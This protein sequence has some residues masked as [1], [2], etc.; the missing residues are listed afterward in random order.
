M[1][2]DTLN[3]PWTT[4]RRLGA[5]VLIA[6]SAVA[7]MPVPAAAQSDP[8][9]LTGETVREFVDEFMRDRLDAY[10]IPGAAVAVVSGGEQVF[11]EGYGLADIGAATPVEA[12][13]TFFIGSVPKLFTAT[14][15]M[16]QVEAGT[17]D[18]DTDVNEYLETFQIEDA[19]PGQPITLRHLL[20]H[21]SGFDALLWGTGALEPGDVEPLG[22]FLAGR[23]PE[24]VRPPG[25]VTSYDNYAVALAGHLVEIASGRPYDAY[26]QEEI[27]DPL[28]MTASSMSQ[29]A[30]DSVTADLARG[31]TP[32][33]DGGQS[34]ILGQHGHDAPA[35]SGAIS[36]AVDMSRFML[37]HLGGG[38]IDGTRILSE[39]SAELMHTRQFA[40]DERLPGLGLSFSERF[41]G[42]HRLLE[43]GGDS[44]GFHAL[45]SLLPE[46]DTGVFAVVN[47]DG[48]GDLADELRTAFVDHFFPSEAPQPTPDHVNTAEYG[49]DYRIS[50][51]SES[52]VT[53]VL[54]LIATISV[55]DND[56]G[57]IDVNGERY[58][59]VGPDL[60]ASDS[61]EQVAFRRDA[62]G[63]YLFQ[64]TEP[65]ESYKR[66]PWYEGPTLHLVSAAAALLV[67]LTIVWWPV[68]AL[69]RRRRK[70]AA[71]SGPRVP[72]VLA[73]VAAGAAIAGVIGLVSLGMS[74]AV[75]EAVLVGGTAATSALLALFS[76][77]A[78]A[79]LATAG[80]VAAAWHRSWWG[81]ARR[82][83]YTLIAL[84]LTV[85]LAVAGY[86]RLVGWPWFSP[87]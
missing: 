47:G 76:L 74:P 54:A 87:V 30:P 78:I 51:I 65:A 9:P 14:A 55:S 35:G 81:P 77:A 82:W 80:G 39:A 22:E 8:E 56:D 45:L 5:A 53:K 11:A 62:G 27:F 41:Q 40:N 68:S 38:E 43:H 58:R 31:Y 50:R 72:L 85:F 46:H 23:Q 48:N 61:G 6:A 75:A 79:A 21:T 69:L 83:H 33:G 15:V 86:Y 44:P 29:P 60:F 28:G 2:H 20:T 26:V 7:A 10:D 19:Y 13:T 4:I 3:P 18:L 25:Q 37:A 49:G 73:G 64:S 1:R 42:D 70:P 67:L 57:S 59:P 12:D 71:A 66:L 17:L 84:A 36:S 34:P 24:R 63:L 52:D 16:Q 32:D